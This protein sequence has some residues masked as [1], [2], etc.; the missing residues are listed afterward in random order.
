MNP[1]IMATIMSINNDLNITPMIIDENRCIYQN[2]SSQN[3]VKLPSHAGHRVQCSDTREAAAMKYQHI[4]NYPRIVSPRN[5]HISEHCV[6]CGQHDLPI[7]AQNK[8][9]CKPCDS[10]YWLVRKLDI[11]VKF[12]KGED[13]KEID[14]MNNSDT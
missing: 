8:S 10:A 6:M 1:G 2:F 11:V 9:I 7:P 5:S 4:I 3:S 14:C 12:C 13:M